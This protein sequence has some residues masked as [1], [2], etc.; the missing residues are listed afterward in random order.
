MKCE[1]KLCAFHKKD[2][3]KC[4]SCGAKPNYIDEKCSRCFECE[5]KEG[6]LRWDDTD[7]TN[8]EANAQ[9]NKPN[10]PHEIMVVAR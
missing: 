2:C 3:K 6:R 10:K 5:N 1:Q 4:E 7:I 9:V 8:K